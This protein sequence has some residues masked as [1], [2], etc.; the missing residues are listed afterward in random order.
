MEDLQL[1][2]LQRTVVGDGSRAPVDPSAD[3]V[4]SQFLQRFA[5]GSGQRSGRGA[6]A[7]ML[8]E[9]AAVLE[10]ADCQWL[11]GDFPQKATLALLRELA[12]SLNHYAAPL[13]QATE[14]GGLPRDGDPSC[15]T[16]AEQAVDVGLV[17]RSIVTK[18]DAAKSREGL[19]PRVADS[20]LSHVAGPTF[21]F[22]LTHMD[23]RP[24]TKPSS[25][26]VAQELLDKLLHASDCRSVSEFLRG[27]HEGSDGWF[28]LVMEYLKTDLNRE[29]WDQNPATKHVFSAVL[30]QVTRPWLAQHLDKVLPPSLLL[31]DD[32]RLENKILGVQCLH[33]IIRN[34]VRKGPWK[35]QSLRAPTLMHIDTPL[36]TKIKDF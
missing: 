2:S 19:G 8:G 22:A 35:F 15:V 7:G 32:Y 6:K 33:H 9:L 23:E 14:P 21:V 5:D 28:E 25:R 26:R 29:T 4:L 12:V 1:E 20:V 34:V 24:W 27:A 17:L 3:Q 10:A 11:F 31:S 18:A 16:L 13:Q 30:Q 36:E